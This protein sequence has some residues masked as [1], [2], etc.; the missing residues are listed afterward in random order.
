MLS[1]DSPLVECVRPAALAVD[2]NTLTLFE[3]PSRFFMENFHLGL[4]NARAFETRR[5]FH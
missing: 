2:R 5:N 4:I 3:R 1:A